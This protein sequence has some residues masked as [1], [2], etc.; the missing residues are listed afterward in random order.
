MMIAR[1]E[2]QKEMRI[3]FR[4]EYKEQERGKTSKL[5]GKT[6]TRMTTTMRVTF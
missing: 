6:R 5:T 2:R 4:G 1:E 3:H